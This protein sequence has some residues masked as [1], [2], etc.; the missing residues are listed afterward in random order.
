MVVTVMMQREQRLGERVGEESGYLLG[1]LA[2]GEEKRK[3]LPSIRS[4]ELRLQER[5]K[6]G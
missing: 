2:K 4:G 6:Q 3:T 5:V 1:K